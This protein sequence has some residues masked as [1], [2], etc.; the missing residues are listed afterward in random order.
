MKKLY[1]VCLLLLVMCTAAQAASSPASPYDLTAPADVLL[2]DNDSSLTLERGAARVV[3]MGM[4]RVPDADPQAALLRL[5]TQFDAASSEGVFLTLNEGF[6]GLMAMSED[7]LEGLNAERIDVI[8]VMVLREGELLILSGYHM[9][10]DLEAVITLLNDLLT[11][12]TLNGQPVVAEAP[13][14]EYREIRFV[15]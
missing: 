8:T 12:T 9:E 3:V 5:M 7:K 4:S 15:D 6:D 2:T 13:I 14:P 11:E 10:N 1:I